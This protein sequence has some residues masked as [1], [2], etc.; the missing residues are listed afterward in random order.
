[1]SQAIDKLILVQLSNSHDSKDRFLYK[2]IR[3]HH[4]Y[5]KS[6]ERNLLKQNQTQII[7][8]LDG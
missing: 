5:S 6:E 7:N 2:E 4:L 3:S 8:R 1:M